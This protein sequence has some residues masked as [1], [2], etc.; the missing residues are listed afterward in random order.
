MPKSIERQPIAKVHGLISVSQDWWWCEV[1]PNVRETHAQ[2]SLGQRVPVMRSTKRM[3]QHLSVHVCG[4]DI[5]ITIGDLASFVFVSR[6]RNRC[7]S[8]K[9]REYARSM[10][11]DGFHKKD[12]C[13][14]SS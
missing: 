10:A 9:T 1:E 8:K 2:E 11:C 14:C 3:F 6:P 5:H 4:D 12:L 7:A 13:A